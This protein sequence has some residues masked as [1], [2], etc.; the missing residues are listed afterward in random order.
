M[1]AEKAEN[2]KE[3]E[4]MKEDKEEVEEGKSSGGG[5]GRREKKVEEGN[6]EAAS[7]ILVSHGL[8]SARK[9]H[10]VDMWA[11]VSPVV[12]TGFRFPRHLEKKEGKMP[13]N[14]TRQDQIYF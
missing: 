6:F 13:L 10:E 9:V 3:E 2:R 14:L 12:F 11:L 8:G 4:G 5:R 1:E 7:S